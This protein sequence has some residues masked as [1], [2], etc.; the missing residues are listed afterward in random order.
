MPRAANLRVASRRSPAKLI[1]SVDRPRFVTQGPKR[2]MSPL[3]PSATSRDVGF[4]A[5]IE[6]IADIERTVI[7]AAPT[8]AI[9]M[10]ASGGGQVVSF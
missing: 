10:L 8:R 2:M 4:H 6:G 5:A 9:A 1:R 7:R 3:G